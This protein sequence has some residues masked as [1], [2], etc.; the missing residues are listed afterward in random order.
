ML[1]PKGSILLINRTEALDEILISLQNKAGNIQIIPLYSKENQVAK[2]VVVVAQ[3]TLRG[4]TK[5]LPPFYTHNEDGT[6]TTKAEQILR[7]GLGYF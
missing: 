2:R 4:I 5:I 3:K 7:N 6:Y 1:K